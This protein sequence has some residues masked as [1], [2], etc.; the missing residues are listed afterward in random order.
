[1]IAPEATAEIWGLFKGNFGFTQQVTLG[2]IVIVKRQKKV[3]ILMMK[4]KQ[5][6]Y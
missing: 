5:N 6:L 1:L 4:E 3:N 2:N